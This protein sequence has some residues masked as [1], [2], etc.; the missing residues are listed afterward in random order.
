MAGSEDNSVHAASFDMKVTWAE[1][2]FNASRRFHIEKLKA[3]FFPP[4]E[5]SLEWSEDSTR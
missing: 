3:V 4:T 5:E 1:E 2:S